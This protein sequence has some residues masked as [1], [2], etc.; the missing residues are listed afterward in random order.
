MQPGSADVPSH[1]QRVKASSSNLYPAPFPRLFVA[2][3]AFSFLP[4]SQTRSSPVL[5]PDH[6]QSPEYRPILSNRCSRHSARRSKPGS[7]RTKIDCEPRFNSRHL[8][9]GSKKTVD[10]TA[11]AA[12]E[13]EKVSAVF[14]PTSNATAADDPDTMRQ[15]KWEHIRPLVGTAVK[16]TRA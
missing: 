4:S 14:A 13:N 8:Q 16:A 1:L 9:G 6:S 7:R 11:V 2:P 10:D 12:A 5:Q 15:E 3:R